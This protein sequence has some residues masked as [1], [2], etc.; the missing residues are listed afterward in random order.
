MN[1]TYLDLSN[2]KFSGRIPFYLERLRRFAI[3]ESW[4]GKNKTPNF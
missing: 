4:L 2:N 1:L 3:N